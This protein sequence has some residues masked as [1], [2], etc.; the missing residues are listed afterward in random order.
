M[1]LSVKKTF[2]G[3]T[4]LGEVGHWDCVLGDLILCQDFLSQQPPQPGCHELRSSASPPPSA[5]M[6]CLT[7]GPERTKPI[8]ID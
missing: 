8:S 7:I 4:L 3:G 1:A 2:G 5:M 6:K